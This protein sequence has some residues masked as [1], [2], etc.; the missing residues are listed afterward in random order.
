[1]LKLMVIS[2]LYFEK[3]IH[4]LKYIFWPQEFPKGNLNGTLLSIFMDENKILIAFFKNQEIFF[5]IMVP[6]VIL[7]LLVYA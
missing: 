6:Y 4:G 5:L 2:R 7:W 1:M 3:L